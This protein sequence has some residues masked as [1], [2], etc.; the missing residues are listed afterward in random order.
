MLSGGTDPVGYNF[1]VGWGF[2]GSALHHYASWPRF[3]PGD[4]TMRT[5][6]GRGLNWPIRYDDLRP[7]Y[8]LI[9]E[10]VGIAGDAAQEVWRPLG[11]PYPMPPMKTFAQHRVLKRGFDRLGL[12]V[13]PMPLAVTSVEYKGRPPCVYDGWCDAGCPVLALANPLVVHQPAAIAKGA[14]FVAHAQVTGI[15]TDAQGRATGLNYISNGNARLHQPAETIILAGAAVQN[16]RLLLA[17]RSARHPNGFANRSGLVGAYYASHSVIAA[18]GLFPD[19]TEP[20][21][22][23]ASGVLTSQDR[24]GKAD[25]DKP[26][27]SY[28]WGLG[29]G[30]KPN[31]LIGIAATRPDIIGPALDPWMKRAARHFGA[32]NA[33]CETVPQ[34]TNRIELT[35]QC[36]AYGM[37]LARI[38]HSLDKDDAALWRHAAKEGVALLK[39]A[40]ADDAWVPPRPA[41]GHISGGTIMGEDP[42]A[43]VAD[44]YGRLHDAPNVVAVGGGLF[45]TIGAVSPTFTLLALGERTAQRMIAQPQAFA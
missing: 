35:D 4:F 14:R 12:H 29:S 33:I 23:L 30:M 1:G 41:F 2:G 10:E 22:G 36:D 34:R 31:D 28:T 3:H 44:S 27:G 42:E 7:Y 39:A 38:V 32:I 17:S 40:G 37:P 26:F 45:P 19:E 8:D 6:H 24:Y 5:D 9:Q 15:T 25:P 16:A 43:S 18:S 20:H 13:A 21:M 11:A